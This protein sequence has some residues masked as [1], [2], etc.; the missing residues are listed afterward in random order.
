MTMNETN[1]PTTADEIAQL[2]SAPFP[3]EEIRWK[4]KIVKGNRAL[5]IAYVDARAIQDRLDET[6]GV[7]GWQDQYR[8]LPGGSVICRLR[9]RIAGQWIS[10]SDVGSPSEQSDAGD[11]TKAAFSDALK[12]AAVKFGIGRYLYRLPLSWTDYDPETK[13]LTKTPQLPAWAFPVECKVDSARDGTDQP[14]LHVA[15][16]AKAATRTLKDRQRTSTGNGTPAQ[17]VDE[18]TVAG[19]EETVREAVEAG[20]I[21][22]SQFQGWVREFGVPNVGALTAAGLHSLRKRLLDRMA[23]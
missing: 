9:L 11:R 3:V 15:K 23:A 18:S 21:T 8:E 7:D 10:K 6:L 20:R 16:K 14:R 19:L 17:A 1:R 2:L 5:A 13:R 22:E 4:P 12:R